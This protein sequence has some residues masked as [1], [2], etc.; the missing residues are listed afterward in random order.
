VA[1]AHRGNDIFGEVCQGRE[2]TRGEYVRAIYAGKASENALP[3]VK[4][5]RL[6]FA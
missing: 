3:K 2:V 1:H 5:L 6:L 4:P